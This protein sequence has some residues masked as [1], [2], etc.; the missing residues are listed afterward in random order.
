MNTNIVTKN[1]SPWSKTVSEITLESAGL[2]W[3]VTKNPLVTLL[4]GKYPLPLESHVSINRDDTHASL[5]IVGAGY[6]P[7]QNSQ[8]WEAAHRGMK[9]AAFD[10]VGGGYTHGGARVFLQ[11]DVK[12]FSHPQEVNGDQFRN[13]ITVYS[14]HDGSS[15]FE[16][17]DTNVRVICSNTLQ[18]ARR[19]GG[20]KLKLKLKHTTNVQ[21]RFDNMLAEVDRIFAQRQ[22]TWR[23]LTYLNELM[24]DKHA[25]RE[26]AVGFFASANKL[27]TQTLGRA[28]EVVEL[29]HNGRGNLGQ[30]AYDLFNGV[31]EMLTHGRKGSNL[32]P[33]ARFQ[34]SEHGSAATVKAHA[35]DR[36][37]NG[38]TRATDI[39]LGRQLLMSA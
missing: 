10:V 39:V 1:G 8:M 7:I 15:A 4:D 6:G 38:Q 30:T 24:M 9:G 17:F 28:N 20:K 29:A 21:Y 32:T 23:D 12:S 31:T 37:I 3:N 22:R 34:A 14:S 25:M 19:Q 11:L 33:E 13:F 36:L 16:L 5:G 18:A 26:W 35:L 27:T 2:D